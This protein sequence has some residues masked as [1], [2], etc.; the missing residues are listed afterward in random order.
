[1]SWVLY[2]SDGSIKQT[3]VDSTAIHTD[4]SGEIAAVTEKTTT[5]AN[6]ELLIE[7]SADTN[8]K[9][10][11]KLSSLSSGIFG[12]ALPENVSIDLDSALSAD[13]K[14]SGIAEAGTAGATLVFGDICYL[15]V[16][17]SR[18]ELANAVAASSSGGKIG[19]CVLAASGDGESTKMLL[20]GKIRAGTVFPTFTVAA[21]VYISAA[22]AGDIVVAAPTGTTNFV[23][24]RIGFGN[25]D[26][27]LFFCPENSY[28]VLV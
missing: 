19:I 25:T 21:P 2:A 11:A 27:E 15:A 9:K 13:G 23:V 8:S 26:D 12:V 7:D 14:Y 1:M 18:W 16:G 24:R 5:V 6:D 28:V 22:V 20:Y 10:S 17:D 4:V 3:D